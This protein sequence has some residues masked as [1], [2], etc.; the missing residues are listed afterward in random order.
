[1]C[2]FFILLNRDG[3]F[4]ALDYI[5]GE[6]LSHLLKIKIVYFNLHGVTKTVGGAKVP[7][8]ALHVEF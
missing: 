8:T 1:M 3:C 4:R 7:C 2:L 5:T 6:F